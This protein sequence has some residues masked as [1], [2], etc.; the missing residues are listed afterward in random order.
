M[1]RLLHALL[2]ALVA[3]SFSGAAHAADP[4]GLWWA[5]GGSAQVEIRHCA[6]GLCG[7][8]VWLRSPI[9]EYGCALRDDQ[10][11]D[12]ELRRRD[13]IGIELLRGLRPSVG[14]ADEW[15]GGDIYD[16]TSGRTYSA[17]IQLDALDRLQVRGYLG[18]PLLGRTTVWNRVR[19]NATTATGDAQCHAPI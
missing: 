2:W 3:G 9:D 17:V 4:V 18:I 7:Q 14:V 13:M 8:V 12:S 19:R 15:S 16:P 1:R 5:E 10:N 11:P 6:D